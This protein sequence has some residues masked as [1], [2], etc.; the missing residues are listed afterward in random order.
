MKSREIK[1]RVDLPDLEELQGILNYYPGE[2][3]SIDNID[4]DSYI[5]PILKKNGIDISE[6]D[7]LENEKLVNF[8]V[9]IVRTC[10]ADAELIAYKEG[11]V[12]RYSREFYDEIGGYLEEIID[13]EKYGWDLTRD[14]ANYIDF[15]DWMLDL[16]NSRA[17]VECILNLDKISEE[18]W[19]SMYV[20][21]FYIPY[22]EV[23][24]K[25]TAKEK[26]KL[27]D[28][29]VGYLETDV[30]VAILT[31]NEVAIKVIGQ[32]SDI[33]L[34]DDTA[35][36]REWEYLFNEKVKENIEEIKKLI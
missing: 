23:K 10:S 12:K 27:I 4:I 13:A 24:K 25:V 20:E 34:V 36:E 14:M 2:G 30:E 26:E 18:E 21:E 19:L 17:V 11:T 5:L 35:F 28:I 1:V 32:T 15:T 7:L 29:I 16:D 33:A 8:L 31:F 3:V 9:P 6:D 22:D